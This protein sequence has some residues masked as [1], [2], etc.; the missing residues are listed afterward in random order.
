MSF[1]ILLV[2]GHTPGYNACKTTGVNEGDLNVELVKILYKLLSPY[3]NVTV[4]PCERD[5]YKD[6]KNGCCKVN[7]SNYRYIFEV[8]FNAFNGNA[9]GTSIILHK[10]YSGG[11]SVEQSII[12]NVAAFGFKKRGT[13]G[14]V[15]RDDLLNMNT[16]LRKGIDYALIEVCFYDSIA[17]MAI[18]NKNK[19]GIASG[20][21][22]GII[23]RFGL[24]TSKGNS[25]LVKG[26]VV[27]CSA[28][29]VR[30]NPNGKTIVGVI[31][32]GSTV[33]IIGEGK[34]SDGDTW[35]KVQAGSMVGFVWTKYIG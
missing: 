22:K 16:C 1:N 15:R 34:D 2:S 30:S 33:Y 5:M 4:Y 31:A 20:I 12:D 17:D 13:N 35:Y 24:D 3:A 32:G 9:R 10:N 18:Y 25:D 27:G 19:N 6:I 8:H 28:L 23:D 11:I 14:I 7:L 21:A 26:T 29:N